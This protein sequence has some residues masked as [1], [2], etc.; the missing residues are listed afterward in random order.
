MS[1]YEIRALCLSLPGFSEDCPFDESTLAFRVG[2]KIFLL[3]DSVAFTGLNLKCDP[4]LAVELR[5][6]YSAVKP[7]FHMNK[8]HWNTVE[9]PGDYPASELKDWILHSYQLVL[10]GLP[11]KIRKQISHSSEH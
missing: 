9:I 10:E 5:E 4:G 7:G 6:R 11:L 1:L 2:G 3:C 8:K